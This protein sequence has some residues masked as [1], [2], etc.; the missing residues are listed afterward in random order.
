M[1][2]NDKFPFRWWGRLYSVFERSKAYNLTFRSPS[3]EIVLAELL[4]FCGVA[5]EAPRVDSMFEQGR[6]A[7]RRDVGLRIMEHLNLRPEE[8]Y[9][10]LQGRSILKP[11]DFQR[12]S[13]ANNR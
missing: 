7:G 11:A 1:T 9:A 4:A 3:G 8:L 5:D 2:L 13:N 12:G 6:V 10:V